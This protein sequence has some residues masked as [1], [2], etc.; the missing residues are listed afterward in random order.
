MLKGASNASAALMTEVVPV[1][2]VSMVDQNLN[3]IYAQ[4][5]NILISFMI[6]KI[7]LPE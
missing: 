1:M 2:V 4:D 5:P 7:G 3:T 6:R